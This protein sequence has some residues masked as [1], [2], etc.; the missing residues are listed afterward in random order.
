MKALT[1]GSSSVAAGSKTRMVLGSVRL[2]SGVAIGIPC[3]V[4]NGIEAG[5][6]LVVSGATH[7]SE[8]AGTAAIIELMRNLDPQ[9]MCGTVIA[10]PVANPLA[11]D[12]GAYATPQD[13]R[14][15]ASRI[16]WEANPN[17]TM[18]ER[19][20]AIL[21]PIYQ[22]ADYYIDL[23]GNHEPAAPMSMLFLSCSRDADVRANTIKLGDAFGVTPVDMSDPQAHPAWVGSV[24]Q[25]PVPVA[26]AN[27]IPALMIELISSHTTLDASRG[28][29]GVMN[30][31]KELKMIDGSK[32]QQEPQALPGRYHYWGSLVANVAGLVWPRVAPGK[33]VAKNEPVFDVTD[34]WGDVMETV[35]SPADGFLWSINGALYGDRT[36]AVPE[37]ADLGFFAER[38][39]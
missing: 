37:G 30:V 22:R 11:F 19:L 35:K 2:P 39:L 13:G 31:M 25:Y 32:E 20:G 1:I 8:I 9:R 33:L 6:T 7:G 29:K 36:H 4:A 28:R 38:V 5:P 34:L 12:H 16:Y 24:D 3:V 15:M 21:S 26:M 14:N 18:T 10:I 27:G 17:G 23:H